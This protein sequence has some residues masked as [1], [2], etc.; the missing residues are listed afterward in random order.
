MPRDF[1]RNQ[2]RARI[3]HL[4]ARLMAEDGIEDY[5]L[6]KRK[7]ARQVGVTGLKQLPDNA[8]IDIA[9]KS[10]R[11]LYCRE[12]K[13]ELRALRKL[14]LT[15]MDEFAQFE[16]LLVGPVLS[17]S[18]GKFATIQLQLFSENSKDV[19]L[20]LINHGVEYN[21][22]T[23]RY[24]A[25]EFSLDVPTLAFVHSEINIHLILLSLCDLRRTLKAGVE[26]KPIER[27]SRATLAA[28]LVA[29]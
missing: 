24:Y 29:E 19:E 1:G 20:Y 2:A 9:L 28:L 22:G 13:H 18:A 17:G 21:G 11:A 7:A 27:A 10:Y 8:E 16:P 3:A 5:A 25:G 12:H 15:I 26:G 4:A 23:N 6:A 14:A